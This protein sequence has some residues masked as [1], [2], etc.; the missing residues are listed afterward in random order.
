MADFQ[1][2]RAP[3]KGTDRKSFLGGGGIALIAIAALVI[4]VMFLGGVFN[5]FF[6]DEDIAPAALND[7]APT[8]GVEDP[9]IVVEEPMGDAAAPLTTEGQ[10]T[11]MTTVPTT[12][13]DD[14]GD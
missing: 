9:N 2:P 6:A 1:Q 5:M 7:G 14:T 3:A 12:P 8:I 10:G 11:T 13:I 4:G